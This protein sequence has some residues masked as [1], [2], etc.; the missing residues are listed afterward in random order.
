MKKNEPIL[1]ELGYCHPSAANWSYHL[2]LIVD[3]T[4]AK[5]YHEKFGGDSRVIEALEKQGIKAIRMHTGRGTEIEYT[6]RDIKDL[7]DIETY[8]GQNWRREDNNS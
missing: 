2:W 4:G 3:N 7:Q 1:V 8:N 6:C 5:L